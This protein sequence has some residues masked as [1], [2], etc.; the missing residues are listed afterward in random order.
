M[1]LGLHIHIQKK[2]KK[3]KNLNP[4]LTIFTKIN[5]KWTTDLN[6]KHRNYK[7]SR[8][9]MGEKLNNLGFGNDIL[10]TTPRMYFMKERTDKLDFIKMKNFCSVQDTVKT[11]RRQTTIW[12]KI[13]TRV[14]SDTGLLSKYTKNP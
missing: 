1:V 11:S 3:K 7:N 4:H 13:F 8:S 2:K 14:I 6:V 5:S 10:N 9:N 12:E